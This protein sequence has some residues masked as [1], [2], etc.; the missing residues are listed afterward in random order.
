MS[1]YSNNVFANRILDVILMI[2]FLIISSIIILYIFNYG[3]REA[4][5]GFIVLTFSP[6]ISLGTLVPFVIIIMKPQSLKLKRILFFIIIT[7]TYLPF[8]LTLIS[9]VILCLFNNNQLNPDLPLEA[10]IKKGLILLLVYVLFIIFSRRI[11]FQ[12]GKNIK[13][14]F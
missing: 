4:W 11:T 10:A 6:F 7:V 2:I 14:T 8:I 3:S 13:T 9:Y 12:E 1:I 5:A